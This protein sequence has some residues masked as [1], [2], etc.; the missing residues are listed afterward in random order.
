MRFFCQNAGQTFHFLTY[1]STKITH[2]KSIGDTQ[3][4]TH[5]HTRALSLLP[6]L[7]CCC[8]C[9]CSSRCVFYFP[10]FSEEV[11]FLFFF[12]NQNALK[13]RLKHP[14]FYREKPF[15]QCIS[16][17]GPPAQPQ[18]LSYVRIYIAS[19]A[20]SL[21]FCCHWRVLPCR[22]NTALGGGGGNST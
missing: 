7:S 17:A 16:V 5:T 3:T 9:R 11:S 21:L 10:C 14:T 13:S 4:H 20:V 6:P 8:L 2:R 22:M 18:L 19:P 15:R 12:G 1:S